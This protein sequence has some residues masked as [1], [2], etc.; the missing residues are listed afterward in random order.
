[1]VVVAWATID[2]EGADPEKEVH[3]RIREED[4]HVRCYRHVLDTMYRGG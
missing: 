1:L 3:R 2:A 4:E